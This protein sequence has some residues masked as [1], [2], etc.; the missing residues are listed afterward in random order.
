MI[1]ILPVDDVAARR[2]PCS[3]KFRT[4]RYK[5]PN[6]KLAYSNYC[7]KEKYSWPLFPIALFEIEH[8]T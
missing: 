4:K 2:H 6:I 1:W 5:G 8:K 3:F 7:R